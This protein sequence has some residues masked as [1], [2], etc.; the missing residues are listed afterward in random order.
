MRLILVRHGNTFNE[1]DK[2]IRI[3]SNQD[4][5]LTEKGIKQ[6]ETI[7]KAIKN[8]SINLDVIYSSKLQ[9]TKKTAEIISN[10]IALNKEVV[11]DHRI[12]EINYGLWSGL[13]DKEIGQNFGKQ[14]LDAWNNAGIWPS[15]AAWQPQESLLFY[16]VRS[17]CAD[18]LTRYK[19][20][21]V[22]AVTSNGILRYFLK[23]FSGEFDKKVKE[24]KL[25]VHT[26]NCVDIVL[27]SLSNMFLKAWNV[28]PDDL[29]A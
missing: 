17:F 27:N 18:I 2:I 8:K 23:L 9:R 1:G 29:E 20:G 21:K 14:S 25:K 28:S 22:L 12:N 24:N 7:G 11:L 4:L 16:E 5:S 15:D 6:A 10:I 3:G 19:R 26:G 13:T